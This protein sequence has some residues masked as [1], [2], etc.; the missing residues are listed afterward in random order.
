MVIGSREAT[1]SLSDVSSVADLLEALGTGRSSRN[2]NT[3][4]RQ[5]RKHSSSFE[6]NAGMG[7]YMLEEEEQWATVLIREIKIALIKTRSTIFDRKENRSQTNPS[8]SKGLLDNKKSS[9][10]LSIADKDSALSFG[11]ESNAG[12]TALIQGNEIDV[13]SADGT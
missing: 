5:R 7:M 11:T 4:E 6:S 2:E 8:S 1:K 13:K 10:S 3:R 12:N 9:T